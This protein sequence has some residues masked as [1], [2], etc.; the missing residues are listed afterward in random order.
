MH[1]EH[2]AIGTVDL[3]RLKS[4]YENWFGAKSSDKYTNSAKGYE[5]YFL[6]FASGARMEIMK[7]VDVVYSDAGEDVPM[8]GYAHAAFSVGSREEVDELTE[9]LRKA[10]VKVVDG[11]R[12]TGDGYYESVVLDPDGNRL[13]ITV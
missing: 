1:I 4:F 3:E 9:R 7:R 2:I 8:A 12:T 10:G 5:S 13:E 6:S 11:P